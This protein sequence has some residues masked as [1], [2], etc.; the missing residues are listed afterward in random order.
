MAEGK[1]LPNP[2]Q[3]VVN[4]INRQ[5]GVKSQ[6][7]TAAETVRGQLSETKGQ[8]GAKDQEIARIVYQI[9]KIDAAQDNRNLLNKIAA[10]V[11]GRSRVE[12]KIQERLSKSK[13]ALSEQYDNLSAKAASQQ[14]AVEG[15]QKTAAHAA[16]VAEAN[17]KNI[18]AE[19]GK[20]PWEQRVVTQQATETLTHFLEK[21]QSLKFYQEQGYSPAE[22]KY[23]F[24]PKTIA[25]LRTGII[26]KRYASTLAENQ[27]LLLRYQNELDE[28]KRSGERVS[29]YALE[30]NIK[31]QTGHLQKITATVNSEADRAVVNMTPFYEET[32]RYAE[33]NKLKFDEKF[34]AKMAI[35]GMA[36]FDHQNEGRD[37]LQGNGQRNIGI[38]GY[39][40]M[41]AAHLGRLFYGRT[42][43]GYDR[44]PYVIAYAAGDLVSGFDDYSAENLRRWLAETVPVTSVRQPDWMSEALNSKSLGYGHFLMADTDRLADVYQSPANA[45]AGEITAVNY[46]NEI[47]KKIRDIIRSHRGIGDAQARFEKSW[48]SGAM[49]SFEAIPLPAGA[50]VAQPVR[51]EEAVTIR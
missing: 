41:G 22:T 36:I 4:V 32:V 40:A 10:W 33:E 17:K 50:A 47:V 3:R 24:S 11:S 49:R 30:R 2:A 20:Q 48:A 37:L 27:G 31:E 45:S 34:F 51:A 23:L 44:I 21:Q 6:A 28:I 25:T 38:V 1:S 35:E 9:E 14:K 42:L 26:E 7:S 43:Q 18:T 29:T 12:G 5:E 15:H 8:V 16:T 19:K 13:N 46:A 39:H